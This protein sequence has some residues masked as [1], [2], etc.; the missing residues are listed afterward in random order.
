MWTILNKHEFGQKMKALEERFGISLSHLQTY[1]FMI[2]EKQDR[3]NISS[4]EALQQDL[5][6]IRVDSIGLLFARCGRLPEDFKPT[7]NVI[8]IFGKHATKNILDLTE[9]QKRQF[10]RGL[11]FLITEDQQKQISD[12]FVIVRV[13][14]DYFGIAIVQGN[15]LKNQVPKTRRV[16]KL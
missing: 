4:P 16:K 6:N 1:G 14:E 11:D 15:R 8:Q 2:N 10:V 7:T 13:K 9:E 12:G 5:N 3:I